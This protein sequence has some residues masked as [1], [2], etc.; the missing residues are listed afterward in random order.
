VHENVGG[1]VK[2]YVYGSEGQELTVVDGSQ[3]LIQGE[4]YFDGHLLGTQ[5]ASGFAWAHADELGTVRLRSNSAGSAIETDTSWPF[6]A[7]VNAVGSYSNLHF[8]GKYRDGESGL[9]YFAARYY[10]SALGRFTTPDWSATPEAVPYAN[11]GN[12][13][14]LNLYGYQ[15]NNPTTNVDADGHCWPLCTIVAGAAIGAFTGAA[16][17]YIGE[18]V[19]GEKIDWDRV[20][21][22]AL[23]GGAEGALTG[24]AG[25]EAG[26]A[27]KAGF[28]AAGATTGGVVKRSLD[29][30]RGL[31]PAAMLSDAATSVAIPAA[32]KGLT[33]AELSS[34]AIRKAT[35]QVIE[36]GVVVIGAVLDGAAPKGKMCK[37]HTPCGE[38]P[39]TPGGLNQPQKLHNGGN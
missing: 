35:R 8:T 6:G 17:E 7:H 25:P 15:G 26:L 33:D 30:E 16:A 23:A 19:R 28:A 21:D 31:Y 29:G 18:R 4:T 12:P 37:E 22:A 13:Q 38:Q 36:K 39:Q 2:E 27:L 20:G 10:S 24:A 32:A 9:D 1:V 3:N 5:E 11:L 14:S 34:P